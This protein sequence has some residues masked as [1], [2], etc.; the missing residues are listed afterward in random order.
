MAAQ[1]YMVH[2][3]AHWADPIYFGDYPEELKEQLGRLSAQEGHDVSRLPEFSDEEKELI[4]VGFTGFL[5][6]FLKKHP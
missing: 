6:K 2:H 4:K 3:I 5:L 1:R